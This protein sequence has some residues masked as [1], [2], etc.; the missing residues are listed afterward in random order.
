[1][2]VVSEMSWLALA[3]GLVMLPLDVWLWKR[4]RAAA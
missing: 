2:D 4:R 1:M 3:V